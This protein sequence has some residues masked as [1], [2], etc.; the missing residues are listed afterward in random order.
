MLNEQHKRNYVDTSRDK[1]GVEIAAGPQRMRYDF[2]VDGKA[3]L[4]AQTIKLRKIA[5]IS[6]VIMRREAPFTRT[7]Q[8]LLSYV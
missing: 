8:S 4:P 5:N 2:R 6:T 7:I 1:A 3:V